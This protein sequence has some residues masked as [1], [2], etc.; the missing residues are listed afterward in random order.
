MS[1][2]DYP[3]DDHRLDLFED[4]PEYYGFDFR[5]QTCNNVF[6]SKSSSKDSPLSSLLKI[7]DKKCCS[8]SPVGSKIPAQL[9]INE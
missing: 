3:F 8:R 7:T 4:C 1:I 5:N 2:N 6:N 9:L